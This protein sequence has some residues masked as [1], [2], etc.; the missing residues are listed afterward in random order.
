MPKALREPVLRLG[1]WV[2]V[3]LL[4]SSAGSS[5]EIAGFQTPWYGAPRGQSGAI[6]RL[7]L[8]TGDCV[9]DPTTLC[10]DGG[11]FRVTADWKSPDGA[12]ASAHANALTADSGSFWF[13]EPDSVE[14][15][16]KVLNACGANGA[17]WVFGAGLTNVEVTT[18]VVDTHSGFLR[19]YTNAQGSPFAPIQDTAAF[20]TCP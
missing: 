4:A 19:E 6:D 13:F 18:R 1:I 9:A 20:A 2:V 3:A 5:Q 12:A 7:A 10:L 15:V 16:F 8:D 14:L 11:R 17:Y